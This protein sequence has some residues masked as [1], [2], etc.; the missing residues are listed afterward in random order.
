MFVAIYRWRLKPGSEAS[1]AQGWARIT[2]LA[3]EQCGS[4]G[5]ALFKGTDGLWYAIARWPSRQDRDRCFDDGP[6]DDRASAAMNEAIDERLPSIELESV[7]NL[8]APD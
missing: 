2:E 5:S 4:G 7:H 3:S 6:L 1:F 8:W